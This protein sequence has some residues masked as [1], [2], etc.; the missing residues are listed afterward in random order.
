M[1]TSTKDF[2][3]LLGVPESAGQDAIKKAYRKLA[4]KHHPDAN[5]GDPKATERFKEIGEAYGVLSDEEKRKQYDQM[6]KLGAF[7]F[8]GTPG[9][10][11]PRTGAG[12]LGSTDGGGA[13]SFDDL[14]GLGD[15][16]SS[17][18]DRGRRGPGA[19]RS[20]GPGRGRDVEY[21]VEI[22]FETAVKGGKISISVPI[23]EECA[24]CSGSGARP[25]SKIESCS[26]C[27]GTGTVSFGQGGFTVNRPCPA[28]L[29]RGKVPE[30]ACPSCAGSG[31]VRQARTVQVT[32]PAGAETGS[33]LRLSGQGERGAA[34]GEP[35]DLILTFQVKTD[36][37]FRREG[38]DIHVTI[39]I[40]VAQAL[41]GS[42]VRVR[43]VDGRHVVLKIPPGTQ[44]GT[45]FRI[46]GQGVESKGRR[47]DQFVEVKVEMPDTIP[48]EGKERIREFAALS[49]LRY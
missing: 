11:G 18:F 39:P 37:F 21:Q 6:R 27:Q 1:T 30:S 19:E 24:T 3:Q 44:S 25:G 26:E 49:G 40:N 33:K 9:G 13:F 16:F 7:G 35:G 8:R 34:G 5:H 48:E 17:I 47:G 41:L 20:Q 12:G 23:T 4:K 15:I 45:R 14:G 38:A 46:R 2:Y 29:G 36:R 31:S 10:S 28:C 22:S 32:V 42:K 43:T